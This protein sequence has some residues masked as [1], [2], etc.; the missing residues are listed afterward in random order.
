M[1]KKIFKILDEFKAGEISREQAYQRLNR[2]IREE[3]NGG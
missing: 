2:I 1:D 3:L